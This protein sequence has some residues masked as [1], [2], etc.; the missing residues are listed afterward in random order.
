MHFSDGSLRTA[1]PNAEPVTTYPFESAPIP[2]VYTR[3]HSHPHLVAREHYAPRT[4]ARTSWTNYLLRSESLANA[5]WTKT[6]LTVTAAATASPRDGLSTIERLVESSATG[7]HSITQ[8]ST[9]PLGP[10]T[11]SL[12]L[13]QGERRFALVT[14]SNGTDGTIAT[15]TLDLEAGVVIAGTATLKPC[16]AGWRVSLTGTAT[17]ANTAL[18]VALTTDGGTTSYAGDTAKGLYAGEAQIVAGST[19]APYI[20]TTTATH[21]IS[22]PDCHPADPYAYLVA[23]PLRDLTHNQRTFTRDYAR[24]PLQQI[25]YRSRAITKPILPTLANVAAYY[26]DNTIAEGNMR[27]YTTG[28]NWYFAANA[29]YGTE[30]ATT[31]VTSGSDTRITATAHG[32]AGTE[33]IMVYGNKGSGLRHHVVEPADY[34]VIDANTIDILGYDFT[35][36]ATALYPYVRAYTPGTDR[37]R[38]KRITDYYLPG[39]TDGVTTAADIPIVSPAFDDAAFLALIVGASS[40]YQDYDAEELSPWLGPIYQQTTIQID[41]DS[42]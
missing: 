7:A 22:A 27:R 38:T 29:L 41:L 36:T 35:T 39:V 21:T 34:S 19:W 15:A 30:Q 37:V 23:E 33:N 25:A 42:L 17:V 26:L 5:A 4:A 10:C 1:R 9:V 20:A 28:G 12:Y 16:G 11:G 32:V 2:D 14:L 3:V 8:A 40:G 24:V 31:S 6:N 13:A 18:T